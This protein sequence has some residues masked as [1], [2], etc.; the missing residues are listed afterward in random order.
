MKIKST[1]L[2]LLFVLLAGCCPTKLGPPGDASSRAWAPKEANVPGTII[3][4]HGGETGPIHIREDNTTVRNCTVL[5][6]IRIWGI[7]RNGEEPKLYDLSRKP[8]YVHTIRQSAPT[9]TIIEDST[10]RSTKMIPIYVGPG[11][12]FTTIRNVKITGTSAS[13]M[14]YLGAE[15][16]HTLIEDSIID[17][18]NGSR[19]AIAIDA[20]DYNI[21]QNNVINHTKGGIYMYRNCGEGGTIRHTTPSYNTIELNKINGDGVA[22]WIGSREGGRCYCEADKGFDFGSSGSDMDHARFNVVRNN[23]LVNGTIRV[24]KHSHSNK[25]ENNSID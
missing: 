7:A 6:D 16:H 22:I 24:G 23:K 13:V 9:G 25:I 19:E 20:S 12:T 15:S 8:D 14:I 17:S 4:C 3:D 1:I 5:G 10:I 18:A 11:S 2:T 21:I